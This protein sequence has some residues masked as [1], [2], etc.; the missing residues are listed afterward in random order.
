MYLLGAVCRSD[1]SGLCGSLLERD[2]SWEM[3]SREVKK[4][5]TPGLPGGIVQLPSEVR[6]RKNPP[7]PAAGSRRGQC[8]FGEEDGS[9]ADEFSPGLLFKLRR[10][11]SP[12]SSEPDS[13]LV[14]Q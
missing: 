7:R 3:G 1:L 10:S 4:S 11:E 14:T 6:W 5:S 8:Q 2:A 9:S 13:G 12:D